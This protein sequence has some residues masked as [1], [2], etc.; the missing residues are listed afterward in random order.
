[1]YSKTKIFINLPVKDLTKSMAFFTKLDFTFNSKITDKNATC[2]IVGENIFVMLLVERFFKTFTKK[3][4]SDAKRN[5][6]VIVA[7]SVDSK[8]KVDKIINKV[9]AAGG[10]ISSN[11]N[12]QDL[13]YGCIFQDLDG[14]L[15][16][17]FYMDKS[18][19]TK[20]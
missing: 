17:I 12:D 14:H 8:E 10:T 4:I 6:E 16:E 2:M 15:W 19:T 20:D 7:L 18:I 9:L 3:E 13:M 5:A 1:M 11:P